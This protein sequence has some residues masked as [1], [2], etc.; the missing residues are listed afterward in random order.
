MTPRSSCPGEECYS[1]PGRSYFRFSGESTLYLKD[2]R[3]SRSLNPPFFLT[4]GAAVLTPAASSLETSRR[5][6]VRGSPAYQPV[7]LATRSPPSR[8]R[9]LVYP[10]PA[11]LVDWSTAINSPGS[12]APRWESFLPPSGGR[13]LFAFS[14][15]VAVAFDNG[16]LGMV[17]QTIQQGGDTSR[18]GRQT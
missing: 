10:N 7:L 16:H 8:N 13:F 18:I 15:P 1:S 6:P 17:Q 14:F 12:T 5:R 2:G 3:A 11:K 4:V 9:G